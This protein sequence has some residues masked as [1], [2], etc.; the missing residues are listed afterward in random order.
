MT[1]LKTQ[2]PLAGMRIVE[3]ASFIAAPSCALH[4]QQ[5]GAEVI[6]CDPIGGGPD[7]S[8][9]PKATNGRSLYWEGLNKGKKSI[10]INLRAAEG[11]EL[12]KN[13]AAAPGDDSGLFVTNFPENGFCPTRSC[14]SC[15]L[16]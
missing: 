14:R 5:F 4:F 10:A 9:W 15:A 11:R 8:R 12:L 16:T 3:A 6:R 1:G 2:G 7:Y 13:L